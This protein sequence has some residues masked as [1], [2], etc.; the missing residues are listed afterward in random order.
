MDMKLSKS[1]R[2]VEKMNK[3]ETSPFW[4]GSEHPG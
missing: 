3:L 2:E 4:E 1:S